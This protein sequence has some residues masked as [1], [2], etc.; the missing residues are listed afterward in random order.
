MTRSLVSLGFVK[1]SIFLCFLSIVGRADNSFPL[2]LLRF[3][4][5]YAF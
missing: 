5:D 4:I 2:V 3:R 1:V